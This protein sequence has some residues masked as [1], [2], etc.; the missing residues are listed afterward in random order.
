[1]EYIEDATPGPGAYN[2]D[3]SSL[4]SMLKQ[5]SGKKIEKFGVTMERFRVNK[6]KVREAQTFINPVHPTFKKT[7]QAS[8]DL[9]GFGKGTKG[10][11][12]LEPVHNGVFYQDVKSLENVSKKNI[13]KSKNNVKFG[14]E[15][16][17]ERF[18]YLRAKRV[19]SDSEEE[20]IEYD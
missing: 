1:M 4:T 3:T 5:T 19:S 16:C 9:V 13:L 11:K 2:L 7:S 20:I 12:E 8:Q 18:D 10:E 15:S 17:Q 6:N 14:F